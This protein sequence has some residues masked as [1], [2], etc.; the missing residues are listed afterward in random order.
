MGEGREPTPEFG[1]EDGGFHPPYAC[2]AAEKDLVAWL[3]RKF[4]LK[5]ETG[6]RGFAYPAKLDSVLRGFH[7]IP[8]PHGP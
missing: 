8:A 2:W 5:R 6:S 4:K 3:D 7:A 1:R